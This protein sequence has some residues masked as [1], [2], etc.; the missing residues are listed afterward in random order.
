MNIG[1]TWLLFL[2]GQ[3]TALEAH[4]ACFVSQTSTV[5]KVFIYVQAN[6]A[7]KHVQ[8]NIQEHFLFSGRKS[9]MK[10]DLKCILILKMLSMNCQH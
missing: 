9:I 7:R 5:E 2:T 6:R 4:L 3:A 8:T 1:D 10:T